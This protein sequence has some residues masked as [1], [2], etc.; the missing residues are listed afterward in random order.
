MIDLFTSYWVTAVPTVVTGLIFLGIMKK[1]RDE[2]AKKE[3]AL[4]PVPVQKKN[5]G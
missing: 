1:M 4:V 2:K 5:Q 3:K